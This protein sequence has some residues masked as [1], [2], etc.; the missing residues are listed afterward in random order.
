MARGMNKCQIIGNLGADPEMR[1]TQ[2]G[3]AVCNFRV[4]VNSSKKNAQGEYEEVTEWFRCVTWEKQA[5]NANEFLRQGSKVYVEGPLQSR[6]Y[7][8]KDGNERTSTE[9][10]VKE[11]L[12]LSS[13][14]DQGGGQQPQQS[15]G[16]RPAPQARPQSRPAQ[17]S[18]PADYDDLDDVPF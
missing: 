7:T 1:Y 17:R 18:A 3:T 10:N 6:P 15:S 11:L 2:S 4:A 9:I 13:R 16:Q 8:D 5:E 14:D 12:F